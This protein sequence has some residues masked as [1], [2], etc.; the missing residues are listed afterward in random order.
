[1]ETLT[2]YFYRVRIVQNRV[3][4]YR[5]SYYEAPSLFPVQVKKMP[6]QWF[7]SDS[8]APM[9][10]V[11]SVLLKENIDFRNQQ[12]KGVVMYPIFSS[13]LETPEEYFQRLLK[14]EISYPEMGE[15]VPNF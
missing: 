4:G 6:D 3:D 11:S 8:W 5:K 12:I 14:G 7:R 1:M 2:R 15:K 9:I 13:T 10:I